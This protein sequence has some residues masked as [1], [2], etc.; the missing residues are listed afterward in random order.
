VEIKKAD[1]SSLEELIQLGIKQ[2]TFDIA[3]VRHPCF[4]EEA[5]EAF[6]K[7]F[8]IVIPALL[9]TGGMLIISLYLPVERQFFLKE[10]P[11]AVHRKL[12]TLLFDIQY[13]FLK[14]DNFETKR[15]KFMLYY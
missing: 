2:N 10:T 3:I 9:K 12:D 4:A 15:D 14:E 13:H 8:R 7:M 11:D 6:K 1:A 5:E